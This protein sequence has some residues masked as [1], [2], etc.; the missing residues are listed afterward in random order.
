M[1]RL[2]WT[3]PALN[4]LEAIAEYIALDKPDAAGRYVQRVFQAV[5]RLIRFP[6]SGSVPPE[7][8][9]LPY[10]QIVVPPC[11]V[12]YRVEG[13]IIF[14]VFVMRAEQRFVEGNLTRDMGT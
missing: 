6:K 1:A 2:I 13:E 10:R 4:D 12:F 11:R 14:V 3:E 8:P 5:E 7:I 9:H